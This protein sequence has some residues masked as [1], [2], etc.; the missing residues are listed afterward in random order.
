MVV[1]APRIPRD[2]PAQRTVLRSRGLAADARS[3]TV[4]SV[5]GHSWTFGLEDLEDALL[6]THVGGEPLSAGHG[7]PLRLVVPGR[8]GFQWIKWVGGVEVR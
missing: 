4:T 3:V 8:R 2:P 7:A 6:A 1:V 5:T